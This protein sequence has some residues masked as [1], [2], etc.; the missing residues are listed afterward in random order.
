MSGAVPREPGGFC[1]A[2]GGSCDLGDVISTIVFLTV[3]VVAIV[4]VATLVVYLLLNHIRD[5]FPSAIE[6]SD[7]G[8]RMSKGSGGMS[9]SSKG[10]VRDSRRE[11][12]RGGPD[13]TSDSHGA[14]AAD[15]LTSAWRPTRP[16]LSRAAME[17]QIQLRVEQGR[18]D[19]EN[20]GTDDARGH[21]S[22]R[23]RGQSESLAGKK[24]RLRRDT[25]RWLPGYY[26]RSSD[27]LE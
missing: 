10:F 1:F 3:L 25:N 27:V 8:Q 16:R 5:R 7:A 20:D 15:R 4:A 26:R 11:Q 17:R 18:Q 19:A 9:A 23:W 14:G 6:E 21:E 2:V 12:L 24:E 13:K 22:A